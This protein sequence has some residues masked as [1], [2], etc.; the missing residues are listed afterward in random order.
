MNRY[1]IQLIAFILLLGS[2]CVSFAASETNWDELTPSV[3]KVLQP[4]SGQ[5]R[6]FDDATRERLIKGADRWVNMTPE[7]KFKAKKQFGQWKNL[8]EDKKK[9]VRHRFDRF[10]Q[11]PPEQ[12]RRM[13]RAFQSF[14]KL[15]KD[16]K[17]EL[18]ARYE[19]MTAEEKKAFLDGAMMASPNKHR[20]N[21]G[22]AARKRPPIPPEER[23]QFRELINTLAP[24]VK[25]I[26]FKMMTH[27]PPENR[28]AFRKK[29]YAMTPEQSRAW[30]L[31]H[32]QELK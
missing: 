26:M 24:D 10:R 4:F 16:K 15:P 8:P 22:L 28:S 17:A 3:Q 19:K 14:Q 18:K 23:Q 21:P 12:Q 1:Y 11:L 32:K 25:K 27:M 29:L 30:L 31:E 6:D 9:Q 7:E 5:W 13:R 20:K 2:T